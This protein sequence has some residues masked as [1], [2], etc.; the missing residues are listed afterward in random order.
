MWVKVDDAF[1]QDAVFLWRTGQVFLFPGLK[2]N[3]FSDVFSY[4]LPYFFPVK[5]R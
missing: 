4:V 2:E 1:V 3:G 5:L